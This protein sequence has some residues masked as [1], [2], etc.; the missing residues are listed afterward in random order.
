[1]SCRKRGATTGMVSIVL[2]TAI[3]SN[4]VAGQVN[5]NQS[6]TITFEFSEDPGNTFS[7]DSISLTGGALSNLSTSGLRRT[8]TF[9]PQEN[10]DGKATVSVGNNRFQDAKG[11]LNQDGGEANNSQR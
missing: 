11:N 9:T 10:F 4:A 3:S 2:A 6:A 1:M 7:A 5:A 8:A